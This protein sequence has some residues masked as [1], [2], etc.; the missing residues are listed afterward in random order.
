MWTQATY[1]LQEALPCLQKEL[2]PYYCQIRFWG[3]RPSVLVDFLLPPLKASV[4][5]VNGQKGTE[6]A[7]VLVDCSS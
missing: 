3:F 2:P 1:L 4:I 6:I 7:R 5:Y